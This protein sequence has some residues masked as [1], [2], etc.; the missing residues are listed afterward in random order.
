[1]NN[2]EWVQALKNLPK[3]NRPHGTKAD[4]ELQKGNKKAV[5]NNL[6]EGDANNE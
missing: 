6:K 4:E 1:M 5:S 3:I 2:P